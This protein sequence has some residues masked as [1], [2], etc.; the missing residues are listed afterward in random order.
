MT[1]QSSLGA[2]TIVIQFD[3]DRNIDSAAQDVQS[4]ITSASKTLPQSLSRPPYYKKVNPADV[5]IL[6]F[7]VHSDTVPLIQVDEYANIFLAQQISQVS[8]V[9]QV[10]VFGDRAP[11]IRI[12]VDPAKLAATGMTL[13]DIRGTLVNARPM[14]PR[15]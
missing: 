13:E 11:S 6:L 12:Q 9:S 3:L 5:P 4:A 8:G 2:S 10:L 1:S 15:V 14:R 7:S